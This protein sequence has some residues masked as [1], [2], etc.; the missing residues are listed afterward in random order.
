MQKKKNKKINGFYYPENQL[1]WLKYD[2]SLKIGLLQFNWRF[3]M[4][5][6]TS[7]EKKT[8]SISQQISF[9]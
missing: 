9:H 2:L 8:V 6:K 7:E 1:H 3:P 4:E 5:G